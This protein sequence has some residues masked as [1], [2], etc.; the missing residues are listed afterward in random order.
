MRWRDSTALY[1][2]PPLFNIRYSM[3]YGSPRKERWGKGIWLP[4]LVS[5]VPVVSEKTIKI[6]KHSENDQNGRQVSDDNTSQTLWI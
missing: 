2:E 1:I 5:I 3:D 6:Q 4:S